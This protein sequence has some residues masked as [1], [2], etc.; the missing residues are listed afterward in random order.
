MD[1]TDI[2]AGLKELDRLAMIE[3][4]ESIVVVAD[5]PDRLRRLAGIMIKEPFGRAS[6]TEHR[7]TRTGARQYWD[8]DADKLAKADHSLPEYQMLELLRDFDQL[9]PDEYGITVLTA[10]TMNER[11]L[12]KVVAEWLRAKHNRDDKS[13]RELYEA[14]ESP[15]AEKALDF[16]DLLANFALAPVYAI[17]FPAGAF[18]IP[19]LLLAAKHGYKEVFKND[20]ERDSD[21]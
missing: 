8:W 10:R 1:R 9:P 6:A 7:P 19:I 4:G 12:F 2:E 21:S 11:G 13:L 16:A 5:D 18:V 14:T 3:Y 20:E 17:L 15:R